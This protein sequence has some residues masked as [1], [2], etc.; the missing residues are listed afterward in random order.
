MKTMVEKRV[1]KEGDGKDNSYI[2]SGG[3]L[4]YAASFDVKPL[5]ALSNQSLLLAPCSTKPT[6]SRRLLTTIVIERKIPKSGT[7]NLRGEWVEK[8]PIQKEL[9]LLAKKK[10]KI[11]HKEGQVTID[12]L[13]QQNKKQT[14]KMKWMNE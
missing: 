5:P 7:S 14:D 4:R 13:N 2:E 6:H 11:D 12:E 1:S 3:G 9:L 10:R 8:A